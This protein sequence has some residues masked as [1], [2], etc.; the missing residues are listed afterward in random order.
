M[1]LAIKTLLQRQ[2]SHIKKNTSSDENDLLYEETKKKIN[3]NHNKNETVYCAL[4]K[5]KYK[6]KRK[7]KNQIKKLRNI[8]SI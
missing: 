8:N 5:M 6:F 7:W 2:F 3:S 1:N 4:N